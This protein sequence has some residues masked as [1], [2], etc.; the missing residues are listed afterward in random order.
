MSDFAQLIAVAA[1]A[2]GMIAVFALLIFGFRMLLRGENRGKAALM[3]VLA[4]VI[5]ANIFIMT[6]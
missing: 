4:V 5:L 1:P 2:L 6:L 3:L